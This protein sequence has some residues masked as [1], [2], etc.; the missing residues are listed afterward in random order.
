ME[1]HLFCSSQNYFFSDISYKAEPA[2]LQ[3]RK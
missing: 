2:L 3:N 1:G